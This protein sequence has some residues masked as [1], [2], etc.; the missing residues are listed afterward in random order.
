MASLVRSFLFGKS[1]RHLSEAYPLEAAIQFSRYTEKV[2][3]I[4]SQREGLFLPPLRKF[5]VVEAAPRKPPL[6]TNWE[7]ILD[8]YEAVLNFLKKPLHLFLKRVRVW[9]PSNRK[10]LPSIGRQRER[11]FM[12]PLAEKLL[13]W[14][15]LS[16]KTALLTNWEL[17]REITNRFWRN[18]EMLFLQ[19]NE[20]Y[21]RLWQSELNNFKTSFT[22]SQKRGGVWGGVFDNFSSVLKISPFTF[23]LPNF[24]RIF[25]Q[26]FRFFYWQAKKWAPA[27]LQKQTLTWIFG[28][29]WP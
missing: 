7:I 20:N 22:Y 17:F 21:L 24:F 2:S 9:W 25:P 10:I 5:F 26:I 11:P 27:S 14:K 23:S 29:Y 8:L 16:R 13:L 18:F 4:G 1:W 6:L 28:F 15:L 3:S 19:I 12:D